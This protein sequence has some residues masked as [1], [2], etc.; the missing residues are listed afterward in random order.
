V[1]EEFL[2]VCPVHFLASTVIFMLWHSGDKC[3][4]ELGAQCLCGQFFLNGLSLFIL[5]CNWCNLYLNTRI[6]KFGHKEPLENDNMNN[7]YTQSFIWFA[8]WKE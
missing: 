3:Y 5:L 6:L 2:V 8:M 4:D 1:A 7:F